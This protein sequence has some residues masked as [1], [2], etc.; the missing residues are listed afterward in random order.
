MRR[1]GVCRAVYDCITASGSE[2]C[3][4]AGFLLDGR[5]DLLEAYVLLGDVAGSIL[6]DAPSEL[7]AVDAAAESFAI[8]QGNICP[9]TI[10]SGCEQATLLLSCLPSFWRRSILDVHSQCYCCCNCHLKACL[11]AETQCISH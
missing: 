9:V 8:S 3:S 6:S 5:A 2:D 7:Y 10:I 4:L 11:F 1:L